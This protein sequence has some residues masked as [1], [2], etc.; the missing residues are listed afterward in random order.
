V[1]NFGTD[2]DAVPFKY[3]DGRDREYNVTRLIE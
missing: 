1:A 2:L 3:P